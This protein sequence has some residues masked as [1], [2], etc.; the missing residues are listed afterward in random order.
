MNDK[1]PKNKKVVLYLPPEDYK[2]LQIKTIQEGK[3]V[4][5]WFREVVKSFLLSA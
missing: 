3:K 5:Q 2:A 4:S 1:L